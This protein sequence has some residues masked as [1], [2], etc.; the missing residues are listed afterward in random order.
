MVDWLAITTLFPGWSLTEIKK[1]SFRERRNWLNVAKEYRKV[2][3][4]SE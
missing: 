3:S 2:V 1:L 4:S